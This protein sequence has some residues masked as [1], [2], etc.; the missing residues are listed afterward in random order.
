MLN[1]A[2]IKRKNV[3]ICSLIGAIG[4]MSCGSGNKDA[5]SAVSIFA[6]AQNEFN[7]ADYS[8]ALTLL[9]SLKKTYPK[10]VATQREALHLRTQIDEKTTLEAIASNDSALNLALKGKESLAPNFQYIKTKDMVEGYWVLKSAAKKQLV[11]RTGIE[12][13]IDEQS[14]IYLV[15]L[16]TAKP[17]KHTRLEVVAGGAKCATKDVPFNGSTNYRFVNDG[18]QNE[19]VTFRAQQCDTLCQ[20]II[21][22]NMKPMKISYVGSSSYSMPLSESDKRMIIDTYNY[23]L[24][25]L[26]SKKH[27]SQKL[28]LANKLKI[29]KEQIKRTQPK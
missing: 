23:S 3:M 16:L 15:S 4:L 14:N 20:F 9:D 1:G 18:V 24:A 17:V 6:Q 29:A 5:E 25:L 13:R 26:G 12:A 10:E 2:I 11:Q 28:Y 8:G 7:Q 19:M 21:D 22:N 27:E